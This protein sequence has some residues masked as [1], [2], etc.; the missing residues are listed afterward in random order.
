MKKKGNGFIYVIMSIIIIIGT[1]VVAWHYSSLNLPCG[2]TFGCMGTPTEAIFATSTVL[3]L[4]AIPLVIG[5]VVNLYTK[6]NIPAIVGIVVHIM[7]CA[8]AINKLW[9]EL[10]HS[11]QLYGPFFEQLFYISIALTVIL[12]LL[13]IKALTDKSKGK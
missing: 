1:A 3:F 12:V 2:G 5:S 10:Q 6:N 7:V 11:N 13:L 8:S 9:E 4:G